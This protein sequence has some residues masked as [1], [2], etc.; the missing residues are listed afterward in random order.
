VTGRSAVVGVLGGVR[1]LAVLVLL[2]SGL[3]AGAFAAQRTPPPPPP[4]ERP[5]DQPAP[6]N[7]DELP[8]SV[9]RIHEGLQREPV[10][11]LV[12]SRPLFRIEVIELRPRWFDVEIDWTDGRR[13]LP[14][15]ST[16]AWHGQFLGMV[17]P[18]EAQA[19]G[20]FTGTDLLQVMATSLVQGLATQAV[21]STVRN[22][23]RERREAEARREVDEA[24]ARWK[25][26]RE[27]AAQEDADP[28][29]PAIPKP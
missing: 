7:V 23:L 28:E 6:V 9:D 26:E 16:P 24:I 1:R 27:A 13:G 18:R 25:R 19:F 22:V 20:A 15:P 3:S 8:I 29:P 4:P 5:A 11:N 10:L 12:P 21:T 2:V 14:T 17:T